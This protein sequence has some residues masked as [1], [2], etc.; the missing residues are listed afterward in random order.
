MEAICEYQIECLF[1]IAAWC[2]SSVH[3]DIRS[4]SANAVSSKAGHGGLAE[5]SVYAYAVHCCSLLV[6]SVTYF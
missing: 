6:R 5:R 4:L 2:I 1:S 3:E